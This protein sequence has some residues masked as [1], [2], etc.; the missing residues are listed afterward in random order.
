MFH[1]IL[2]AT[3][4]SGP[5]DEAVRSAAALA[6]ADGARLTALNLRPFDPAQ[7]RR[8]KDASAASGRAA[9]AEGIACEHASIESDAPWQAIP[10]TAHARGCDLIVMAH[11]L[12]EG[13]D[14]VFAESHAQEVLAH[15]SIPVLVTPR[16][17]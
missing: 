1:H 6:R 12:R 3:D 8:W 14:S 10:D 2:V 15:S 11:H 9:L 13:L 17:A 5:C 4:G 16:P 7:D